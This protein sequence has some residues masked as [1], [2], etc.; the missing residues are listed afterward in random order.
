M[1]KQI[2][3]TVSV[4][5]LI[6]LVH[7]IREHVNEPRVYAALLAD[8]ARFNRVCSAM[9]MIEDTSQGLCAYCE[10]IHDD[11]GKGV[12]NVAHGIGTRT[13][14]CA[15]P[16]SAQSQNSVNR[17]DRQFNWRS[18]SWTANWSAGPVPNMRGLRSLIS[19]KKSTRA[20]R[21]RG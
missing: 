17:G 20:R 5:G 15:G 10:R 4:E 9:D 21:M 19:A 8:P 11:A 18:P 7:R 2:V 3:D 14:R 6:D 16:H 1:T 12:S 13:S